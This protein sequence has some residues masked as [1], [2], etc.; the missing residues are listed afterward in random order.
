MSC[1]A[2]KTFMHPPAMAGA[3]VG[4]ISHRMGGCGRPPCP[5]T[6]SSRPGKPGAL[7]DTAR[8][9]GAAGAP[10]A[11]GALPDILGASA[12]GR[13]GGRGAAEVTMSGESE[14]R[15]T[16]AIIGAGLGGIALV[17]NLGLRG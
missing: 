16:W 14:A 1:C 3:G 8:D 7:L 15:G 9:F 2:S 5:P 10:D 17:A 11:G 13:S 6:R 12:P 4:I